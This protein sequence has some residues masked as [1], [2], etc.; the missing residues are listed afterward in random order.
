VTLPNSLGIGCSTTHIQIGAGQVTFA[1]GA[2]A[3]LNNRQSHTDI[4]GQYGMASTTVYANSGGSA[5][6]YALGGDTE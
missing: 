4:V 6:V 2:S 5:A 1:A 3:T